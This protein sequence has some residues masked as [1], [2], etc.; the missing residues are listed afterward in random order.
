VKSVARGDGKAREGLL[1][2]PLRSSDQLGIH[3]FRQIGARS[4][5]A[6]IRYGRARRQCDSIFSARCN[7]PRDR[8][9]VDRA[10]G[11]DERAADESTVC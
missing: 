7:E 1:V 2:T 10:S 9:S 11:R 8:A 5:R 6:F 3:V 4:F